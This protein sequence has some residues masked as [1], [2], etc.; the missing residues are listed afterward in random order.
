MTEYVL[1]VAAIAAAGYVAYKGLE[2]G[3]NTLVSGVTTTLKGA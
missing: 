2:G 1:I 3:I